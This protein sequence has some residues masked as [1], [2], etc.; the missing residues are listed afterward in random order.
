MGWEEEYSTL[1]KRR[2]S[3]KGKLTR[4]VTLFKEG[5]DRGDHL[6]ALKS[7][8]E[9]V[10]EAF[11]CLESINE[12][13]IDF[14]CENGSDDQ[15][16]KEA[17]QY[18]LESE[19]VKNEA[20]ALMCKA[21][22]ERNLSCKPKVKVKAFEPPKFDGNV[23]DYPNFKEDFKNLV[24]GA[25][26]ADPY[27]LKMCLSGDA[28]QTIRGAEGNYDEMFERLDDKYGNAR[29]IVDLVIGDLKCLRKISD[30]NTKD[31]I[32]MVD[33]VEQCSLDLKKVNLSDELNTA[34]VVSNIERV[35]PSLQKREWVKRAE[36]V[37]T[38]NQLFPELLKFLKEEKR[39]LEYMNSNVRISNGDEVS[40]HSV[41]NT[42][43]NGAESDLL[44]LVR[45]M[46]SD[47]QAKNREFE[48]CIVSLTQM[49]KGTNIKAENNN[50]G[51]WLHN[52]ANHDIM[53]CYKFKI[54]NNKNRFEMA[55]NHGICYK[56]LRGYHSARNC[57]TGKLCDVM[58]EGQGP[59]NRNH[60][61]LLHPEVREGALHNAV[62]GKSST[63]LLNISVVHSRNQPVNV[64]WDSGSDV[65]LITHRMAKKLGLKGKDINLSMIKV[66]NVIEHQ[67]SKEYCI[68]LMHKTGKVWDINVIGINEISTTIKEVDLSQIPE[69]FEGI[70]TLDVCRPR[71]EIDILIG[72]NYS[73]L[74]PR[75]IQTKEGL[76]LL[77]NQFG[78]S[79]RGRHSEITG[80]V[81]TSHSI[82]VRTHNLSNMVHLNE[83][84]IESEVSLKDQLDR[85]FTIEDTGIESDKEC[86]K[87]LSRGWPKT[88]LNL[89]EERELALIEK[90][91]AYD[92]TQKCWIASYPW[93]K[94]PNQLKN[95]IKVAIARLI[96][97]ENRLRKLDIEYARNYQSE[98][99][100][101]VR[102]KI[103]RKLSEREIRDYN[104]PVYYIHHHEVLKPDSSSTPMR[105]VFNSSAS[106]MGQKLNDFWAKGP[107][108]LNN[109][110]GVLF[111]FRQE[112]IAIAGDIS[113][114]YH[115]IKISTL[116]QHTHRFLWRD[117][118]SNRQPDHYVLNSVTFGDRPSGV[119]AT[120]ALRQT[121]NIFGSDFPEV[122]DMIMNNTYVDDIL[123][124]TDDID[125]ALR[126]IRDTEEILSHGRFH[127]KYWVISGCHENHDFNV[128]ESNCEKI[129][130][131]KWKPK[132]DYFF[133]SVNVNFSPRIRKIRSGPK[134][135]R[136]EI[137]AKFPQFLTRRMI[138]SQI[139]SLYDPLGFAVPV[140]L[141]A[142]MMMRSMI[143]RSHSGDK[144]IDWIDPLDTSMVNKWKQFF[145][146]LYELE[147]LTFRRT[148]KPSNAFGR[149]TL[150]IFSD[151]SMH[152]Y[153]ACAY[154]RWQID[155]NKFIASLIVA[156]NKV[157]P[158]KQLSIPR[159]E[160]CGALVAARLRETI[161]Q[162]FTWDFEAI[163][164]IVDSSI[165]R[166]Q[167][168]KE[169]Q[170]FNTFVAVRIAEI[171]SKT[172]P[173][174]WWWT[175]SSKNIADLT[176]KPCGPKDIGKNSTW[177]NG[178]KFLASPVTEWPIRQ[179][180]EEQIPDR[181]GIVMTIARNRMEATNL[182]TINLER[183]GSYS[184][185]LRV[186][187]RVRAV[188]KCKSLKGIFKE[189][190]VED[191]NEAETMWVK[192]MQKDMP[193]W[194]VRFKRLG[195]KLNDGVIV[196][197][198]RISKWLK[199]NWNQESFVLIP[200]S[201]PVTKLYISSLHKR[202]HAGIETTLAKLQRKFWVPGARKVI[203]T[204][205]E[206]CVLCRKL[207][208]KTENQCM[209]QVKDER[210]KP[211]PPFYH[212]AVDLF[213][214][215]TIKDTVK[216]RTHSKAYGVIFN[217]LAT[218]AVYLD[219]AEGY[220]TEDFL[221]TFQRF[222][223]I[224]G[225]PKFIYSDKGTQLVSASKRLGSIGME[226][227][228]TWIFSRPSD[229]PWYNGASESLIKSVKR[230]LCITVGESIL[231]FGDLQTAMFSISNMMNERPI[232]VK[233][234]FNLEL[235]SYLCPNDMLLGRSSSH[236]PSGI[237]DIN[238]SFKRRLAFV[239]RIVDSFWKKW[240]RDYFSTMLCRQ[241]WHITRRNVRI[242][243]I[244]LVQD[245]NT[246]RGAWK[247][248]QVIRATQG[249]DGNV[250][251][252]DLRYK[253]IKDGKGYDGSKDRFMSR[254]V[255]RLVV[256]LP[257]EEQM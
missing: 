220:N 202:D 69:L 89:K 98:V 51:C 122:E 223:A 95:N 20:Q 172:D 200:S 138:L 108:I 144:G 63:A 10:L 178:P 151:G 44:N 19:R 75:V 35:L 43:G 56:C 170:G 90:G 247:L 244:V 4:K 96:T 52:N 59:C 132:E 181:P 251:D 27:A 31:F 41:N 82:V 38:T 146:N 72:T 185:L 187:C 199:E 18:V 12:N 7:N 149:P 248:A 103:A 204:I 169:S 102:R 207:A 78:L 62:S 234:A 127:V 8:Y 241:K 174:E 210:L 148:L 117:M 214:P 156:K 34:N 160:L 124:S 157:A 165:V 137:E 232:G 134:L 238:G 119:I 65:S 167:I 77:E 93:I 216:R 164:H 67:S 3:T 58:I 222:I 186:T 153:G 30:G 189:P 150:I 196:V 218:R 66:G 162:Q 15:L 198:E 183:F 26:G 2:A 86:I 114:M 112:K 14:L 179:T 194:E 188:F 184:K 212:T 24:K 123:H 193:D 36:T 205:K 180:F 110:L 68:P 5:L 182:S 228:V 40:V 239:Q 16:E 79:I 217:C 9:G 126:L 240:Q 256:L 80:S 106:Y 166:S 229:A 219:L 140:I 6:A 133:F 208:K 143:T 121:V 91:L 128:M 159:L 48:S 141:Q 94:D 13:I 233:P 191:V 206:N 227:G 46:S 215:F 57:N 201:H 11:Q 211:A 147:E 158:V 142:K 131:L 213:G 120:L 203:R 175:D 83:I 33:Q 64:L 225:A 243:D 42:S 118:D 257:V 21:E 45:K 107:N 154:V 192:E 28:L 25:Y 136:H 53:D 173:R 60:H 190:T 139:A 47:Q 245:S 92:D 88:V 197:G 130:G 155:E 246:V 39:V 109:L 221:S 145:V 254:S 176:S 17:Q 224:R 135:Q 253:I 76:Q 249:C 104:G 235:G 195:P 230:C 85:F 1:K 226:E 55:K 105:I 242:G 74:L 129:L 29:K 50:G 73:E 231:T 70:S 61:S 87:C 111:R 37:S 115:T 71:G 125:R 116:D 54:M 32:K 100:D 168:Q 163:F 209:G 255:H 49:V 171:Q 22:A 252:V 99:E 250:R 97:T 84:A 161:V 236:C 23:R 177:Q 101:M 113:K 237:Y 81:N 152:A